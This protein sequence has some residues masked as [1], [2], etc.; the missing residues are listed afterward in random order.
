MSVPRDYELDELFDDPQLLQTAYFLKSNQSP[1]PPLDPAFRMALR[2]ELMQRA[3]NMN[4]RRPSWWQ[5]LIAP[6]ALAWGGAAAALVVVALAA[7]IFYAGPRGGGG[8][9]VASGLDRHTNVA[10]VQPIPVSFNQPMDH[11]SVE[12]AVTIQPATKVS[13]QWQ[14]NTLYVQP[15]SGN[16]APSTQYVVQVAPSAQTAAHQPVG[17]PKKITF[18]TQTAPT[19]RPA[20][21]TPSP[22]PSP[23]PAVSAQPLQP[24]GSPWS[25]AA[26]SADA[27]TIYLL[28]GGRLVAV[29]TAGGAVQTLVPDGVKL[30][31]LSTDGSHLAYVRGGSL[32]TLAS[33]GSGTP[34]V[35][36][37]GEPLAIA[38]RQ[39]DVAYVRDQQLVVGNS[40]PVKLSEK[41]V[42][43]WFSPAGDRLLYQGSAATHLVDVASG[44]ESDLSATIVP[45]AWSPDG[46][47]AAWLA[48]DLLMAGDPAS[49]TAT[50]LASVADLG[51]KPTVSWSVSG[52]L[53]LSVQGAIWS[54]GA[55]GS[56]LHKVAA[57]EFGNATWAPDASHV[58]FL[59]SLT[60][61]FGQVTDA[62]P[63]PTTPLREAANKVVGDFLAA[64]VKGDSD[65]AGARLDSDGKQAYAGGLS[66]MVRGDPRLSRSYTVLSEQVGDSSFRYV[67][68]LVLSHNEIDVSQQEETLLVQPDA[69]GRML[70]HG[71]SGAPARALGK[72]PQLVQVTLVDSTHMKIGFDSDLDPSVAQLVEVQSKSEE[73][74]ATGTY[75]DRVVTLTFSHPL[76]PGASYRLVVP[77]TV[78]DVGG[79]S[80]AAEYDLNLVG[81][82]SVAGAP[83]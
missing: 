68:R 31:A 29:P 77:T 24:L 6:P 28:V 76:E 57:G 16:L 8:V 4:R 36:A 14:G 32:E 2:R 22:V 50:K 79:Q 58:A 83:G 80:P 37:A 78:K 9:Q 44:K 65:A 48:G 45:L 7:A 59:R 13:Y 1:E 69:S 11:A 66:L 33:D 19:P 5:A 27:T 34:N 17:A 56:A 20:P 41:P 35:V 81:P 40:K 82:V 3:A 18:V 51:G 64:R 30:A 21:P 74:D 46:K 61:W 25:W 73:L 67:V 47:Q 60:L 72:G 52:R 53:L 38:W 70:I 55:D 15:L 62:R 10:L 49:P 42:A 71:A 12:A 23:T 54:V 43:A 26:W 75:D 63:V 39:S